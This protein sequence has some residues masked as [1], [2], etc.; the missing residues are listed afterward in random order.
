MQTMIQTQARAHYALPATLLKLSASA[1]AFLSK[2]FGDG[3]EDDDDEPG[4]G[5][6]A[7]L[8]KAAKHED[9]ARQLYTENYQ[10]RQQRKQLRAEVKKL[11]EQLPQDGTV[12]LTKE[13]AEDWAKYQ[14]LGKPTDLQKTV[15]DGKAAMGAVAKAQ[16]Q[17][18]LAK[19][20]A[21]VGYNPAVLAQMAEMHNLTLSSQT[22]KVGE[23]DQV[24]HYFTA[25]G[26]QPVEVTQYAAS[27]WQAFMPS[28]QAKA[29]AAPAAG[30][31]TPPAGQQQQ[32][33]WVPAGGAGGQPPAGNTAAEIAQR[34]VQQRQGGQQNPGQQQQQ[35]T[36][37]NQPGTPGTHAQ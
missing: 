24:V 28:L 27:N 10:Y 29:D 32:Q 16:R 2:P 8:T 33:A 3:D 34:L 7:L 12:V 35:Q 9:V 15:D 36:T 31:G 23:K 22:I 20:A 14:E 30:G 6:E 11:K 4:R 19:A 21:D 26:G 25:E 18:S 17:E 13:Q 37:Q 1:L 5:I